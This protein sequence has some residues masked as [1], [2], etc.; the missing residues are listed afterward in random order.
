MNLMARNKLHYFLDFPDQ[1]FFFQAY[2]DSFQYIFQKPM[3]SL[4]SQVN[5]F[6]Y[7]LKKNTMQKIW[8]FLCNF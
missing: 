7:K 6:S 1:Y 5:V 8:C 2:F 3:S 4:T